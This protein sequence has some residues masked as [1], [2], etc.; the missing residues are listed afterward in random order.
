V[1]APRSP[2]IRTAHAPDL[3]QSHLCSVV[4]CIECL[5]RPAEADNPSSWQ[6]AQCSLPLEKLLAR[7]GPL[8][9][10]DAQVP[11]W[12]NIRPLEY[13]SRE[14]C[15][16]PIQFLD[17]SI[18]SPLSALRSALGMA[19][20]VDFFSIRSNKVALGIRRSLESSHLPKHLYIQRHALSLTSAPL[21]DG[22]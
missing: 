18:R 16:Q 6:V 2:T 10:L 7:P 22:R 12:R 9:A 11:V 20:P 4:R 15:I 21:D 14:N 1:T 19:A 13:L 17:A 3:V 8:M 5:I